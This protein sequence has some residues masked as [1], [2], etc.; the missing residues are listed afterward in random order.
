MIGALYR[1]HIRPRAFALDAER[2]HELAARALTATHRSA[3]LRSLVRD[4]LAPRRDPALVMEMFGRE[5]ASPVGVAAGFDKG[6]MMYN[7][8]GAMGFGF[9]EV[10]TVTALAQPGNERPRLFRLPDDR[11][12]VNRMGFNNPGAE[13]AATSIRAE[14]PV[15]VVLGVNLGKSKVTALE[16]AASDYAASAKLLAP[17]ADYVVINVSSPNTPG[18]R[19]LQSVASLREIVRVVRGAAGEAPLLVKI[20]PDLADEDVD[21]VADL[22]LAEGLAGVVATNTTVSRAGL[23]SA[24]EAVEAAGA[25]GLSGAPVRERSTAVIG[26]VWKRTDGRV[27]VVGVGGVFT[28][29]DAWEKV[30]AGASIVQVYTGLVYEGPTLARELCEG[31]SKRVRE[32]GFA[33]LADAVG[34]AHG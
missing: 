11:A 15:D 25:G 30:R 13:A 24:P 29:D 12:V 18:L 26:R 21:D 22:A 32:G 27:P 23:A 14:P 16:E 10:G 34:S 1:D 6:A 20:A 4:A 33:R 28:A 8:L 2:A 31:L 3:W 17:L 7:A 9:V 19:S 5:F